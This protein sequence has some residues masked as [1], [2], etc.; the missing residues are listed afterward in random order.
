VRFPCDR[1]FRGSYWSTYPPNARVATRYPKE[2]DFYFCLLGV[3][4]V[5]EVVEEADPPSESYQG[6]RVYRG[7]SWDY[8]I[9]DAGVTDRYDLSPGEC[10]LDLGFRLV[11]EV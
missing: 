5:E 2:P 9:P 10:L 1:F 8:D 6:D 3:R 7:G 11:E 4:L